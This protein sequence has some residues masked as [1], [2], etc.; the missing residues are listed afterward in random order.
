MGDIHALGMIPHSQD[1]LLLGNL[2]MAPDRC[3]CFTC[4]VARVNETAYHNLAK[5]QNPAAVRKLLGLNCG[6]QPALKPA[7]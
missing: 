7:S 2:G 5:A 3:N 4:N 6:M 1:N